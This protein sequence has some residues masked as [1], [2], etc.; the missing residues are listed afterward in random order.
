MV[1]YV[2]STFQLLRSCYLQGWNAVIIAIT[3]RVL[4]LLLLIDGLRG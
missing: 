3:A 2:D 1:A 4:L